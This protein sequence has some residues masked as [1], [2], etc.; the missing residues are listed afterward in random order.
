M[1]AVLLLVS[2]LVV[3]PPPASSIFFAR[4]RQ[5]LPAV[6]M[7]A[8]DAAPPAAPPADLAPAAPPAKQEKVAVA[9]DAEQHDAW[10][11]GEPIRLVSKTPDGDLDGEW[12][13]DEGNS[14]NR[15]LVIYTGGTLGMSMQN[16]T[17]APEKGFLQRCIIDMPE[18]YADSMP[19]LDYIEYDPPID[20]SNIGPKDWQRLA[21]QIRD[22]YYDYDG[23]VILHG[24]DTMAY[25]ASALSFML[26]N[27]GKAVVL[28]GS[29]I[30]LAEVYN[31]ARRNLL[32]SMVFAAQLELCE[33]AIFF[34]DRLIRGNRASKVDSSALTAFES[35]NFPPL[36]TVGATINA[37]M[38]A[39]RAPPTSRLRVHTNLD[40]NLVCISLAPGFDDSAIN[41][42]IEHAPSLKGIVLSLYGTGNG[43]AQKAEFIRTIKRAIERGIFVVAAT[44]CT[45]G[46]VSLETY[47]VGRALLDLGVVSAGD[48]TTEAVVTKMAYLLGK[49]FKGGPQRLREL[50]YEDLRGER[51]AR[52]QSS[53]KE[54]SS[55]G[56]WGRAFDF[57][58]G[59]KP[60]N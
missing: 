24:T 53:W 52:S 31:D 28:T 9:D 21:R 55:V 58:S 41:A 1:I 6:L 8:P 46:A 15:V 20:S 44:Q 57:S 39:W 10:L 19:E 30:P 43:P 29:M 60:P 7:Q 35:P 54:L 50:M 12:F 42:M 40:T 13:D 56:Q 26:E 23:F 48:M 25:T 22:Y 49:N 37:E 4:S 47:E 14:V 51:T 59:K 16:D 38:A 11:S 2:S 5:S 45:R 36:A 27:L 33:V 3:A 17:L 34:D 18:V 32:I